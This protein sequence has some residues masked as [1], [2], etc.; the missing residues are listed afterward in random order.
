[1]LSKGIQQ[2]TPKFLETVRLM[3]DLQVTREELDLILFFL[4]N[5]D[6]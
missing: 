1:M 4:V 6:K 2:N 5:L 3:L